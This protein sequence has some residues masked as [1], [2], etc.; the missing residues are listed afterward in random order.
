MIKYSEYTG[1]KRNEYIGLLL[2]GDEDESKVYEY[3]DQRRL[4]FS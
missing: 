2:I 3:I 1:N 4:I